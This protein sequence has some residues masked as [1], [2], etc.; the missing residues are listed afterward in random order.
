MLKAIS[1][2]LMT[3]GIIFILGTAG[4]ADLNLISMPQIIIRCIIGLGAMLSGLAIR[5]VAE[6]F[7]TRRR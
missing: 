5:Y 6:N 1:A 7:Q 2:I 3:G 4:S